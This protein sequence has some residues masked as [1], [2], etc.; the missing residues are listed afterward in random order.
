MEDTQ[1]TENNQSSESSFQPSPSGVSFPTVGQPQKSGGAKTLLVVGILILVG[2]LG[3]VIYKSATKTSDTV[4]T[5][6]TPFDNLSAPEG[7]TTVTAA[8][9]APVAT[10]SA[11]DRSKI[12]IQIQNG[13]GITGEAAY[14][15]TQ[16]KDLGYTN[17]KVGNA[18][19]QNLTSTQVTF[20]SSLDAGVV[21]ELTGKLNALYQNV[22]STSS[23]SS[24][25]DIVIVTGL[26]K[27]ST[28]KPSSSPLASPSATP[29]ATASPGN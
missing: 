1:N 9:P 23:A 18:T 27:G 7:D 28:P 16:L 17:V 20:S 25:F 24:T 11:T 14:L 6:P 2:I 26:R 4:S 19:S 15:Q 12:S 10:P 5:E 13:T 29:K 22:T 8:T 3:F 21:S